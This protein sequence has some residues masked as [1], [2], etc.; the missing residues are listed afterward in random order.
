MKKSND[1]DKNSVK[2]FFEIVM[3]KIKRSKSSI[4]M[5]ALYNTLQ[6]L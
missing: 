4:A 1:K 5:F 3:I 2:M 6:Q